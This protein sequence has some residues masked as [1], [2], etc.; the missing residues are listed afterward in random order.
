MITKAV[1]R[2]VLG[3]R[4]LQGI[5]EEGI[6]PGWQRGQQSPLACRGQLPRGQGGQ[7]RWKQVTAASRHSHSRHG[8]SVHVSPLC[9]RN[10]HGKPRHR[11]DLPGAGVKGSTGKESRHFK[12]SQSFSAS[13]SLRKDKA[14]TGK[15]LTP[16]CFS[17]PG[18]EKGI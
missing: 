1:I 15:N 14:P 3:E 7:E 18:P 2:L 4:R 8:P 6:V 5:P 10:T 17:S 16:E 13:S 12:R 11:A 9:R